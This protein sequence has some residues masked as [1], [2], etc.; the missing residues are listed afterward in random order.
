MHVYVC[1][2]VCRVSCVDVCWCVC[3]CVSMCV[4]VCWCVLMWV[5]VCVPLCTSTVSS[6]ISNLP[7]GAIYLCFLMVN[8]F[9]VA[10]A[11]YWLASKCWGAAWL[12]AL[13]ELGLHKWLLHGCLRS[14]L[15]SS[16]LR[17]KQFTHLFGPNTH[18]FKALRKDS[19]R[20]SPVCTIFLPYALGFTWICWCSLYFCW[21]LE[22][23]SSVYLLRAPSVLHLSSVVEDLFSECDIWL[24]SA[25]SCYKQDLHFLEKVWK[26]WK[27][28]SKGGICQVSSKALLGVIGR[29]CS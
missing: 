16:Y 3:V 20:W 14:K 19:H 11:A 21:T 13:P 4:D 7:Y 28:Q 10:G 5:Y 22:P 15:R 8:F 2:Y 23:F 26:S 6:C 12:W 25:F 27:L 29:Y 1:V 17:W 18:N 9:T 24:H